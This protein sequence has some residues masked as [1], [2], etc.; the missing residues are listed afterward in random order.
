VV[1]NGTGRSIG[2]PHTRWTRSC[3]ARLATSSIGWASAAD[4]QPHSSADTGSPDLLAEGSRSSSAATAPT[5]TSD[6]GAATRL[7]APLRARR[8]GLV[9]LQRTRPARLV[10]PSRCAAADG[11]CALQTPSASRRPLV[12]NNPRGSRRRVSHRGSERLG[13]LPPSEPDRVSFITTAMRA[14]SERLARRLPDARSRRFAKARAATRDAPAPSRASVVGVSA[15]TP[16]FN[17][18]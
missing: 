3:E 9:S 17:G 10:P 5:P 12:T 15:Q 13:Q 8:R 7:G 4:E 11:E 14:S 2:R 18:G 1:R 16:P 6:H